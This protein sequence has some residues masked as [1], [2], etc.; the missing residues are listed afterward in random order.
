MDLDQIKYLPDPLKDRYAKLER[1][2]QSDG[3]ALVVDFAKQRA[4]EAQARIVNASTW[5]DVL[6]NRGRL[7]VYAELATLNDTTEAEFAQ[8][9]EN[10]KAQTE[11]EDETKFE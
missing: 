5:E 8:L 7:Q 4:T 1:V 10:A 11:Q 6:L 3:W 9:A 2:F